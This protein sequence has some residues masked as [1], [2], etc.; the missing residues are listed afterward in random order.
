MTR[1]PA[2]RDEQTMNMGQL[3]GPHWLVEALQNPADRN[4]VW[5]QWERLGRPALIPTGVR[6]DGIVLPAVMGR[7]VLD[8]LRTLDGPTGPVLYGV[9]RYTFLVPSGTAAAW[10]ERGTTRT[11]GT[12]SWIVAPKPGEPQ[13]GTVSVHSP[14]WPIPPD[15]SGHLHHPDVLRAAM[16]ATLAAHQRPS[17]FGQQDTEEGGRS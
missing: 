5:R 8:R 9:P 14:S 2:E 3:A 6:F 1:R 16:R 10:E 7:A 17:A 13:D 12:G 15:G 11:L 4:S